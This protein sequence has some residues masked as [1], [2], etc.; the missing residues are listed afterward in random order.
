MFAPGKRDSCQH[1]FAI[2]IVEEDMEVIRNYDICHT[3]CYSNL[4]YELPKLMGLCRISFDFSDRRE[5]QYLERTCPYLSFAFFSG[6]DMTEEECIGLLKAVYE[7][8]T[9]IAGVTRGI[10]GAIFYDGVRIYRQNIKKVDVIDTMGA[11]DSF[12][13]GFLTA[14]ANGTGMEEALDYAAGR[15]AFTCTIGGGFGYPH[16]ID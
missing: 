15:S 4:E 9:K 12:I 7:L 6:S 10:K 8:G 14:Y 11:G 13:A 16:T 5:T 2:K 3:S 1:L